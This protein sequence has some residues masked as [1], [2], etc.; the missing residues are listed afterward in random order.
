MRFLRKVYPH[1]ALLACNAT[2]AMAATW[3]LFALLFDLNPVGMFLPVGLMVLLIQTLLEV[4]DRLHDGRG[5][6]CVVQI[7][8]LTIVSIPAFSYV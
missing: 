3:L 8:R 2:W 1:W 7:V 6:I 5:G 4:Y